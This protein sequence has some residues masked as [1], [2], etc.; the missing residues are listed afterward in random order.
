MKEEISNILLQIDLKIDEI[1][2]YGYDIIE[3]SL[4]MV[5]KLQIIKENLK[6]KNTD[7]DTPKQKT[8]YTLLRSYLHAIEDTEYVRKINLGN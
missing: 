7:F 1:D 5:H 4:S 8:R 2:L 3:D 6:K